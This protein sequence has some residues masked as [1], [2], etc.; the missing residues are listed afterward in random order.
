MADVQGRIQAAIDVMRNRFTLGDL[1]AVTRI[2]RLVAEML[3]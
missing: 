1:S 2:D 3:P